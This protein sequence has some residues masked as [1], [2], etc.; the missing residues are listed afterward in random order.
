LIDRFESG[1]GTQPAGD[2]YGGFFRFGLMEEHFH[3]R[4][5]DAMEPK[6]PVLGCECGEWGCWPLM[7]RITATT[8][9][10]IWDC[11]EQQHRT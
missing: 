9:L 3:G 5:T 1:A 2:A 4:S 7:A 11:F 10:V 6:T 8:D